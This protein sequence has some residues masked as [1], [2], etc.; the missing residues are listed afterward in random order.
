MLAIWTKTIQ[1]AMPYT[2]KIVS[3]THFYILVS[4]GFIC[5]V[6]KNYMSPPKLFNVHIANQIETA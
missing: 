3:Q 6:T 1:Y 5:N 2:A 4:I